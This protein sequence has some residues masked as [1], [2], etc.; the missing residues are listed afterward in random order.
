MSVEIIQKMVYYSYRYAL[1]PLLASHN[2]VKIYY[3]LRL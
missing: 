2:L 1:V 3:I